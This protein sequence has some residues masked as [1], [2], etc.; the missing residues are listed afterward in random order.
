MG[1]AMVLAG[2]VM[3]W[4][5][6]RVAALVVATV[7]IAALGAMTNRDIARDARQATDLSLVRLRRLVEIAASSR[8]VHVEDRH[9]LLPGVS[10]RIHRPPFERRSDP[11]VTRDE[12]GG[13][14]RAF[15][16]ASVRGGDG[17]EIG[18]R[19]LEAD[20]GPYRWRIWLAVLA[21]IL[22]CFLASRAPGPGRATGR[23]DGS[24][25]FSR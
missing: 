7:T 12:S 14:P 21:G 17:L 5:R 8:E 3:G 11:P 13:E 6:V 22:G 15:I 9:A 19:P 23:P 18:V 16:I 25:H 4:P 1:A 2:A 24:G 10:A 20:L